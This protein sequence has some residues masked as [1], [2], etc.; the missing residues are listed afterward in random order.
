METNALPF[1]KKQFEQVLVDYQ[2]EKGILSENELEERK[3]QLYAAFDEA[4]QSI[5]SWEEVYQFAY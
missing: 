1:R 5:D 4:T 3:T 2:I